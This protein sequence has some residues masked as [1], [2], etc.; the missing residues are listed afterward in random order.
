V[1]V[2]VVGAVRGWDDVL[3]LVLE[4]SMLVVVQEVEKLTMVEGAVVP[5]QQILVLVLAALAGR[6][7]SSSDSDFEA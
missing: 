4:V 3:M 7:R 5:V 2:L 6:G 1:V